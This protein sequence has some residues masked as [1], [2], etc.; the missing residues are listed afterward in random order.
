MFVPGDVQL[1]VVAD[2]DLWMRWPPIYAIVLTKNPVLTLIIVL[3]ESFV[4]NFV[5]YWISSPVKK[6]RISAGT[7]AERE[8]AYGGQGSAM[9]FPRICNVSERLVSRPSRVTQILF[10]ADLHRHAS[11]ITRRLST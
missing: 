11:R 9:R 7:Q 10:F 6:G 3:G 1:A 8:K 2:I 4:F 5:I